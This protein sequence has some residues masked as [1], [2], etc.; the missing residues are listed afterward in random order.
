[1]GMRQRLVIAAVMFVAEPLLLAFAPEVGCFSPLGALVPAAQGLS[2]E[3]VGAGDV[4]FLPAGVALAG[5]L[6]WMAAAFAA[7]PR[8]CAGATSSRR[9]TGP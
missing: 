6:A 8:S 3:D 5:L 7:G 2:A 9:L 4:A 1:M